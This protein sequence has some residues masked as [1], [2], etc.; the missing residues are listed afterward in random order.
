M[1]FVAFFF[2]FFGL[3]VCLLGFLVL[4]NKKLFI[5]QLGMGWSKLILSGCPACFAFLF[6]VVLLLVKIEPVVVVE[7]QSCGHYRLI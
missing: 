1:K 2:F 7:T 3:L 4:R 6:A 5:V